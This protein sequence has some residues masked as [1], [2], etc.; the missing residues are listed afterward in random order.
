MLGIA[1]ELADQPPLIGICLATIGSGAAL[2][3][4]RLLRAGLRMLASAL[5][6]TAAK[7]VIKHHVDRTRPRKMLRDGRYA[8][9]ADGKGS[10][11]EGPWN[12]FPSGHT[13]GAVAVG[14]AVTRE[15]P[16]A[17]PA[18]GLAMAT[19][20]LIQLPRGKHF[21]SDVLAGAMIG[22]LSEALVNAAAR[23]LR[24]SAFRQRRGEAPASAACARR[25]WRSP[26][27]APA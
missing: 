21:A 16:A 2:R 10:K 23:R 8:L 25:G 22:A 7:A 19:V 15:Y 12:S 18:T 24:E 1:S 26:R 27:P 13:A 20:G 17:L 5:V 3:R 4:P 14:R 6:A 11:D 9:R